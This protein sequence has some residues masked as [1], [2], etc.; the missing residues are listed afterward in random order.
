M[1]DRYDLYQLGFKTDIIEENLFSASSEGGFSGECSHTPFEAEGIEANVEAA[2]DIDWPSQ[3]AE[4]DAEVWESA[5]HSDLFF[6]LPSGYRL[7][8]ALMLVILQR[9]RTFLL[10]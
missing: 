5:V 8:N 1:D 7:V 9:M 4:S 3:E 10:L 2:L 6:T